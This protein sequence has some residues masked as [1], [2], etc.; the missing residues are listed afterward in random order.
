M[1]IIQSLQEENQNLLS[2]E[3]QRL[4]S[5]FHVLRRSLVTERMKIDEMHLE[6][7]TLHGEIA[8]IIKSAEDD[9]KTIQSQRFE[10]ETAWREKDVAQNRE[11]EAHKQLY[12]LRDK[13][14]DIQKESEKYAHQETDE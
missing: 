12:V 13:M 5:A 4:F 10:I 14:E 11:Q 3:F 7:K 2:E 9:K 8:K 1:Q 6:I